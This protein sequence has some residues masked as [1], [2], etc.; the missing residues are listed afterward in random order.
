MDNQLY[1]KRNGIFVP[2]HDFVRPPTGILKVDLFD[3]KS[4]RLKERQ[5]YK[6]MFVT[7]G[8]QSVA[9][10]LQQDT[11]AGPITWCAVG[12]SG[13]APALADTGLNAEI[14]RKQIGQLSFVVNA[15]T[16]I[17]YFGTGDANGTLLEAGMFGDTG[18]NGAS[19]TPGSGTLFVKAAIN[20]T[21]TINDTLTITWTIAIG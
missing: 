17:T 5:I 10:W 13:V 16:F 14:S 6:N 12:T 11:T 1:E 3:A 19:S 7:I 4:G 8:K 21:K 15:A 2:I 18:A 9:R 20:R